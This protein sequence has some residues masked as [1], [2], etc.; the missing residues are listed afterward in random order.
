VVSCKSDVSN[1]LRAY[2]QL[3]ADWTIAANLIGSI[4][5]VHFQM[6]NSLRRIGGHN[7]D[8]AGIELKYGW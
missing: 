7:A 2:V 4:E 3:R 8:Y 5:A 1:L 6:S